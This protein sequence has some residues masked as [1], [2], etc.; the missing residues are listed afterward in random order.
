MIDKDRFEIIRNKHGTY[1]SWAVWADQ[2]SDKPKSGMG[3]MAIFADHQ[4]DELLPL[5]KTNIIMVGLN[6]S[7]AITDPQP[8]CNF[9]DPS[10]WA[11]D[12]KIRHAFV[13]TDF[14]GAYMTDVI[15]LHEQVD[16]KQVVRHLKAYPNLIEENLRIFREEIADLGV[17]R[18]T[19]LAFGKDAYGLLQSRFA[20]S[21]LTHLIK[22]THYS[23]RIGKEKYKEA[24]L[25]QIRVGMA[26][27][28]RLK[29]KD[30]LA[31]V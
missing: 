20:P 13:G 29:L 26:N 10:P 25:E 19:I 24:I 4:R 6:F 11:N 22:L 18:P 23:H 31:P 8:F 5:L 15:K 2:S 3:D 12:F 21:E 14:Y 16:S 17:S 1:A 28:P 30:G 7:R 9:H 27:T